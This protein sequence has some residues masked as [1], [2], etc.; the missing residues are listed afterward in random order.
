M[1][2]HFHVLQLK[3]VSMEPRTDGEL[4]KMPGPTEAQEPLY[5][6]VPSSPG[7]A[8][9]LDHAG[10]SPESISGR[11]PPWARGAGAGLTDSLEHCCHPGILRGP[12]WLGL[13]SPH[14]RPWD[15]P[16]LLLPPG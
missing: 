5:A 15:P 3:N 7:I 12:H 8:V 6:A 16:P 13:C 2:E 11:K 1:C 4:E 9:T 10:L 14:G